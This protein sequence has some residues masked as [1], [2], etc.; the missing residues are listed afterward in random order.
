M[1]RDTLLL[2]GRE[3][4]DGRATYEAHADRL[5]NRAGVDEVSVATY[6]D[7]PIRE[8]R[9]Q[10]REMSGDRVYAVPMCAAHDHHTLDG[11]PAALSYIDGEVRYCEPPGSSPLVTELLVDRGSALVDDPSSASLIV[12]AFGSSSTPYHRQ[13][14]EYHTARIRDRDVFGQVLPSYLLQNPAVE[15]VRYNVSEPA[16]VAV[17]LFLAPSAATEERIPAEL[18]LGRGGVAYAN[19]LGADA[20]VT[21]AIYSEFVKQRAIER[22][23]TAGPATFEASLAAGSQPLAT[24]GEGVIR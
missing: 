18:E 7:E 3:A 20:R 5:A 2:V 14:V 19:P 8:L 6:V 11:V 13:A 1:T 24:D 10:F 21:D 23:P 4:S 22:D 17:P 16:A 9:E 12:V 15:C